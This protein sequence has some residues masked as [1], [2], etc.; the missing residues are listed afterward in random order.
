L[1]IRPPLTIQE[2]DVRHLL[3]TLDGILRETPFLGPAR[4]VS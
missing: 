4:L 3:A 1:K 2:A